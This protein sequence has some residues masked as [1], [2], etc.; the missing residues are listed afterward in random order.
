MI[1]DEHLPEWAKVKFKKNEA[2]LER[3]S[4]LFPN[5]WEADFSGDGTP[6]IAIFVKNRN[7]DKQGILFLLG[8][9]EFAFLVGVGE[10]FDT[11][12][13]D[14]SRVFD[15]QVV[16]Q[17]ETHETTFQEN[18]DVTGTRK[19]ALERPAIKIEQDEGGGGL[20]YFDSEKFVWIHQ[21]D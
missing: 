14:F 15:W 11:G 21:G 10:L 17:K 13:D 2:T 7:N 6:D 3:S 8:E 20:V 12:G 18:G 16:G 19:I 9:R 4:H 1:D 5:Y